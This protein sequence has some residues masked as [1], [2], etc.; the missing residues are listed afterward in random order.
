MNHNYKNKVYLKGFR[1][2]LLISSRLSGHMNDECDAALYHWYI[3]LVYTSLIL[4]FCNIKSLL[5]TSTIQ[6]ELFYFYVT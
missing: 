4:V 2:G 5:S 1:L 6:A 3:P